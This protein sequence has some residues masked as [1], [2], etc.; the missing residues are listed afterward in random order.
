MQPTLSG[1]PSQV[2]G[3]WDLNA[4]I[5]WPRSMR[6]GTGNKG[7]QAQCQRKG[8]V[9]VGRALESGPMG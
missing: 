1:S 3:G 2:T 8:Q 5:F 6:A 4:K 7:C 9:D